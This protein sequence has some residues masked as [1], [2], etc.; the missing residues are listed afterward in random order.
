MKR[1]TASISPSARIGTPAAVFKPSSR[2]IG[3]RRKILTGWL[4]RSFTHSTCFEAQTRPGRPSFT[5]KLSSSLRFRN[6]DMKWLSPYQAGLHSSLVP[7][8]E[9]TQALPYSQPVSVQIARSR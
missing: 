5:L 7:S 9:E 4:I 2:T 6:P 1:K 8:T 3:A